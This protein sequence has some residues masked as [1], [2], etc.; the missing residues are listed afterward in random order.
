MDGRF[1]DAFTLLP[2]QRVICG[3]ET[4][5]FCLRHR[6]VLTALKSPFSDGGRDILPTD[7]IVAA[8]V[9]SNTNLGEMLQSDPSETDIVEMQRMFGD[10]DYFV[11]QVGN[12]TDYIKSQSHWPVF[13]SKSG[14]G[15][16]K[17][18]PWVLS[19]VC[20]LVKGGISLEEA[21]TMPESQAV[22]MQAAMAIASGA[23]VDIVS[24]N[25][26][27]A[28]KRLEEYIAKQKELEHANV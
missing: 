10:Q 8:R 1:L 3:Y 15:K 16:D 12:V 27:K 17:G 9:L 26:L 14:S 2:R 19:A 21:W 25:D 18:V 24:D 11:E 5:P 13:W 22:W 23:D 28:Q 20:G 4:K 7:V 6:L